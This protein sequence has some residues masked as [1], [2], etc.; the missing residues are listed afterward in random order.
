MAANKVIKIPSKYDEFFKSWL[1]ILKPFHHF[2]EAEMTVAAKILEK[3]DKMKHG[4]IDE[5]LLD[6]MVLSTDI[7][8]EIRSEIN[9]SSGNFQ[10]VLGK[11]KKAK[12]I[13]DGRINKRFV[14]DLNGP[15]YSLMFCFEVE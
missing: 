11:L 4:I 3:R 7:K 8:S 14:P 12:F 1:E 6:K 2:T 9:M 10:V 5:D 13:V 15:N